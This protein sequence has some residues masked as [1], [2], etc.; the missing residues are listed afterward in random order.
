MKISHLILIVCL[1]AVGAH[2]Q[3]ASR[4]V[5]HT[6]NAR[7]VPP[8]AWGMDL[9]MLQYIQDHGVSYRDSGTAQDPLAIFQAHG[10]NYVRL[11]LFVNPNGKDGQVNTRPYT[12]KL[13]QRVKRAG[14][15]LLLDFHYSD[16]WADPTH[17]TIPV[18][19]KTLSHAQLVQRIFAY[20]QETMAAFARAGCLPDMVEV[21]N[22]I[23]NGLLWPD[24]GP[25]SEADKWN[26]IGSEQ[27]WPEADR[28]PATKWD[29]LAD[30]LKAGI[31][32][33]R[34][35]DPKH[36]VKIMI[37]IDKGGNKAVSRLFFDALARRDVRFDVIGL[38]YYPFWHGT[39]ADLADSLAFLSRTYRK[40]IIVVETGYGWNG[41]TQGALPF[42]P[43]PEGQKDF[44]AALI[45]TVQATPGG[46]GKGVFYWAP[47]WIMGR[48]WT[49]PDWS[50]TWENRA[51][52][53]HEGNAL[54]AMGAF[55]PFKHNAHGKQP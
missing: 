4:A 43:T 11:R 13:A 50:P 48:K 45:R 8:F 55:Q 40:D 24:G 42:P 39:L 49:G 9:S 28:P 54:P 51:L 7:P 27:P 29:A 1:L 44:L 35:S 30:L 17:Q 19:W 16:A 10:V 34:A 12:L 31:R 37:H 14:L 23:T 18:A 53:D 20:T 5:M 22:E 21:G 36:T 32:G 6:K 46:H 33:V 15:P 3:T 26:D 47:E 38:S 41:G 2:A 25:L 52:F